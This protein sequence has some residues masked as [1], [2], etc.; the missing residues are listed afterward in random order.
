M[1]GTIG[2]L[3]GM[4]PLASAAF[5]RSIYS[6]YRG[7]KEQATPVVLLYS[8]PRVPDRTAVLL[9]GEDREPILRAIEGA[10]SSLLAIGAQQLVICC[11]TAHYLLH[12]LSP[13]VREHVI[14]LVDLLWRQVHSTPGRCLLIS[15][16][17]TR[18][19]RILQQHALWPELESRIVLPADD[20]QA[21]LH[22]AIYE[23]K[24]SHEVTPLGELVAAVAERHGVQSIAAACTELHLLSAVHAGPTELNT[25]FEIIDPLSTITRII[26]EQRDATTLRP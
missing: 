16:T 6:M 22:D 11:V 9:N 5:V 15:T 4:G 7:Q 1:K 13:H 25:R 19:A 14:S 8:D 26:W 23:L 18:R 17:G 3:G 10:L 24:Q 2:V 12:A 20:E 21:A